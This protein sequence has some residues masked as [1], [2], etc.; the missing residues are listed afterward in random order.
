MIGV[1]LDVFLGEPVEE[2]CSRESVV[3]HL[4]HYL[5]G[6]FLGV[7]VGTLIGSIIGGIGGDILGGIAY[8]LFFGRK[9]QTED[10]GQ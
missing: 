9:P 10:I 1:L 5:V 7:P 2:Q 6:T 4:V 8:D 3:S